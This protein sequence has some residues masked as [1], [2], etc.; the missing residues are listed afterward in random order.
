MMSVNKITRPDTEHHSHAMGV[1]CWILLA[2]VGGCSGPSE[3]ES[4]PTTAPPPPP[5]PTLEYQAEPELEPSIE[6]LKV[7]GVVN[8]WSRLPDIAWGTTIALAHLSKLSYEDG[9]ARDEPL[10]TLG[11]TTIRPLEFGSH[12]GV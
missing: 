12:R 5:V 2:A 11:F 4:K 8:A 3:D 10:A 1:L 6:H 7:D 9:P